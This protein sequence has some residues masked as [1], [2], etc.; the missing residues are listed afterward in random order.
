MTIDDYKTIS[1]EVWKTFKY[2]LNS[3]LS[4]FE[5]RIKSLEQKFGQNEDAMNFCRRL[6][7]V[8]FDEAVKIRG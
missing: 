2:W 6:L 4:E 3:D 8:Y 5:D 7:K 1:N